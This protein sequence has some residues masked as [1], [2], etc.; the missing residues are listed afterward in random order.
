MCS[1]HSQMAP[2]STFT[3]YLADGAFDPKLRLSL[4]RLGRGTGGGLMGLLDSD[5][6]SQRC[7]VVA[8]WSLAFF[9]PFIFVLPVKIASYKKPL[10]TS[11]A[12]PC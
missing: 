8:W 12:V 6:C 11:H 1:D 3:H 5:L 10:S 7:R 4:Q 2:S 9:I